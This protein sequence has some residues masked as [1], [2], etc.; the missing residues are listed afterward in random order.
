VA[1]L[2]GSEFDHVC[3]RLGRARL[4]GK[5]PAD[6]QLADVHGVAENGLDVGGRAFD[7]VA[8]AASAAAIVG[9][10]QVDHAHALLGSTFY[11]AFAAKI[12]IVHV[13]RYPSW[14]LPTAGGLL[15][16]ILIGAWY[17]SAVWFFQQVGVGR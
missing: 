5:A 14:V 11:G 17:T 13:H 4:D 9:R 16:A 15:C 3:A 8:G 10:R 12:L 6:H 7:D 1:R 2:P